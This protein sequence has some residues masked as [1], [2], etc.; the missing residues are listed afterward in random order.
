MDIKLIESVQQRVTK[1]AI[2]L[3]VC[4][5]CNI[6]RAETIGFNAVDEE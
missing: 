4:K 6:M 1:L 2:G 5:A 3:L